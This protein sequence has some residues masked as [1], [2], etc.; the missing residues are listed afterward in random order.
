MPTSGSRARAVKPLSQRLLDAQVAYHLERWSEDRLAGTAAALV[1][2]LLTA[3]AHHQLEDLVDRQ[4]VIDVAV[5]AL[6]TVPASAAAS[7]VV[8]LVT[9]LAL[10]GPDAAVTLGDLTDRERV[11]AV[12]D[13]ALALHPLVERVGERLVDVPLVGTTAARF[14]SRI[15]GEVVQANKAVAGKVP[16]LGPLVSFG[17]SAASKMVGAADRQLEGLLGD[18]M[19]KGGAF[20]VRRLNRIFV[21]TLRDPTTRAAV[22]QAWDLL[23]E[24][25]LVGLGELAPH[26]RVADLAGALQDLAVGS[27]ASEPVA[28]LVEA[29]VHGFLDRFGGY[30]T[31]ELLE[32]FDLTRAELVDGFLAL[33]PPVLRALRGSGDL[34]ALIRAQLEPFYSSPETAALLAT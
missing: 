13:S 32:E 23:A 24:E 25:D 3:G 15:V 27:L 33:A 17:T 22:L 2:D 9:S 18:T 11:E 6:A 26:D 14:M 31:T 29:F 19:D 20:A 34:E 21:E 10:D 1:D 30:T 28:G 16:G 5:R 4:A 7:G 12:L 8:E